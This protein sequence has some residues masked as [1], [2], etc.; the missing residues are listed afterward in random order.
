MAIIRNENPEPDDLAPTKSAERI[1][2]R[3]VKPFILHSCK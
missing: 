2:F 1:M 3:S